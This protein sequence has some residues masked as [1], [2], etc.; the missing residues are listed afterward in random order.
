MA[1]E[2]NGK[3]RLPPGPSTGASR[4]ANPVPRG[5]T[6]TPLP[7]ERLT[8]IFRSGNRVLGVFPLSGT[9][10]F[11]LD[12]LQHV[13]GLLRKSLRQPHPHRCAALGCGFTTNQY[14][15]T[16]IK[17]GVVLVACNRQC[18]EKAEREQAAKREI[19]PDQAGR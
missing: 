3:E 6:L 12:Y 14:R 10:S 8:G 15:Y 16:R 5:G 1:E 13:H 18:F 19:A 7:G 2:R 9:Q 11:Q 17:T 4:P